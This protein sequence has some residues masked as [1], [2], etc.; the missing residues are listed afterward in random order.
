M[1]LASSKDGDVILD[2]FSGSGTTLRVCQQ[3]NRNCIGFELNPEYIQITRKRLN[4]PFT[5]FDSIDPRMERIPNDLND[6]LTRENYLKNHLEWF[7]KQHENEKDVFLRKIEDKYGNKI[8]R[9]KEL[10]NQN[11]IF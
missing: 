11:S 6:D 9:N 8:K 1:V 3:L 4:E 2:P 5:G 10:D 7:L